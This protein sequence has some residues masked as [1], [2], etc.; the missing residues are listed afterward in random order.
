M[1]KILTC[2]II[3]ILILITSA[4]YGIVELPKQRNE[5]IITQVPVMLTGNIPVG[6][7]TGWYVTYDQRYNIFRGMNRS[8]TVSIAIR[9]QQQQLVVERQITGRY[10]GA[11]YINYAQTKLHVLPHSEYLVQCQALLMSSPRLSNKYGDDAIFFYYVIEAKIDF[12]RPLTMIHIE[13]TLK[14]LESARI[15]ILELFK[16]FT[17]I[18]ELPPLPEE[19]ELK[20]VLTPEEKRKMKEDELNKKMRRVPD[21][22]STLS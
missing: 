12:E 1:K 6:I 20:K 19:S 17:T 9:L 15:E 2:C 5:P 4:A 10:I 8:G 14:G 22:R 16:L 7:P 11:A 13:G 18:E 3:S 21:S